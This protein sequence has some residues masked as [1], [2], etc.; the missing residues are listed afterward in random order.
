M[1]VTMVPDNSTEPAIAERHG[2]RQA[3]WGV[4]VYL[5][6]DTERDHDD[7]QHDLDEILSAGGSPDVRI[8][9]QHDGPLGA[10]RYDV[11]S[12][13]S[14]NLTPTHSLGRVD[15]GRPAA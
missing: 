10:A 7:L 1:G 8:V 12:K 4:L 15:S 2:K 9:V 13:P 14:P 5:A 6:G 3:A 11:P